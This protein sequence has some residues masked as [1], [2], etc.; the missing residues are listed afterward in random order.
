MRIN[1]NET[2][3]IRGNW[4]ETVKAS[5]KATW[6]SYSEQPSPNVS[7]RGINFKVT[8]WDAGR[9]DMSIGTMTHKG[10]TWN[11][12]LYDNRGTAV[13]ICRQEKYGIACREQ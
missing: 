11:L 7:V 6:N 3:K 1:L 12:Y 5:L 4:Q 13:T 8:S 10:R 9:G 2:D